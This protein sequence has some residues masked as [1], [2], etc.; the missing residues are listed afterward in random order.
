MRTK[1]LND[2]D[3]K[4]NQKIERQYLSTQLSEGG[5]IGRLKCS[6]SKRRVGFTAAIASH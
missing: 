6:E 2:T 3:Q 5:K 4:Q 1:K